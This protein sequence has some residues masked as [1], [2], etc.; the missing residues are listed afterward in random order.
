MGQALLSLSAEL[1]R[2]VSTAAAL[3]PWEGPSFMDV[4]DL[5]AVKNKDIRA[6]RFYGGLFDRGLSDEARAALVA[7]QC[8][9]NFLDLMC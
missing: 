2:Y 6:I 9:M 7:F 3:V 4:I 8:S 5:H 1:S